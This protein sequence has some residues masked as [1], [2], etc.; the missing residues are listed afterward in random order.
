MRPLHPDDCCPSKS[1]F[2]KSYY[3]HN[4]TTYTIEVRSE[5]LPEGN[6]RLGELVLWVENNNGAITVKLIEEE[7]P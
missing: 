2:Q 4:G 1:R 5:Y 6:M 7:C 3:Q